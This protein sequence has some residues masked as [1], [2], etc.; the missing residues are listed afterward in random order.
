MHHQAVWDENALV[1]S[2]I[3]E[4]YV[5]CHKLFFFFFLFFLSFSFFSSFSFVSFY[6]LFLFIYCIHLFW[7]SC[8]HSQDY[9]LALV[10]SRLFEG[11]NG[12]VFNYVLETHVLPSAL[13][14]NDYT[15]A[16]IAKWLLKKYLLNKIYTSTLISILELNKHLQFFI[17][18]LSS[19]FTLITYTEAL[20][21]L[22]Q[23]TEGNAASQ[24]E[25]HNPEI[26][27]FFKFL[28]YLKN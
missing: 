10:I 23:V 9:Q 1:F 7:F 22:Q 12:P 18:I 19:S 26:L 25:Q 2:N 3:L 15:M 5:L 13:K 8:M 27:N 28:R 14:N 4:T 6:L 11:E 17:K 21:I 24:D 20:T 16:S